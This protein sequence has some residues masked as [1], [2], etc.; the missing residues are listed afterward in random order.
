MILYIT[1]KPSQVNAL[2]DA[3]KKNNMFNNVEIVPLAGH[4]MSLYD[5]KDYDKKLDDYWA[6]LIIDK[7]VP[8]FPK[9]LKKKIKPKSS[10]IANNKKITTDYKKKFA[11][12]KAKI[13]QADKI[14]LAPD[15]D[16]EGATLV[17]EV[18]DECKA[19]SKVQGMIN[20]SKLDL[21]SLSQEV[22]ITT[23]IPY[24]NM[25]KAGDS[26]A[27][28]DQT[29]GINTSIIATIILGGGKTLQVGGV[30]LPTIRMVV[31]RDLAFE[32]HTEVPFWNI[33]AKAEYDKKVFDTEIYLKSMDKDGRFNNEEEAKNIKK[34]VENLL[35]GQILT[36]KELNKKTPPP[37]PYSLTDLQSEV[38]KRY[39][40][41]ADATLKIAQK[42]YADCKIQ[43]YP[44]TDSNYYSEGEYHSVVE[45]LDNLN[46]IS[47][48]KSLIEAIDNISKPLKR[49]IFDD[50]KID[51]HTALAPTMEANN[52]LYSKLSNIDK[53]VFN[54][55]AT[56]YIIQFLNDY[57][58]LD[59]SGTGTITDEIV[60]KFSENIPKKL[61]WKIAIDFTVNK[62]TIPTMQH[63][64]SISIHN[65][66]IS[67][68]KGT[69]KPKPRFT[70]ATLL[71]A[72]EK[73]HRFF[74][75]ENIKKEL[76]ENGIGTPATRAIILEQLKT[77]KPKDE[78]Y[79]KVD[80]KGTITSTSKARNLIKILPD[81][82]SSPILRAN[83]EAKLKEILH[84]NLSKEDYI[85]FVQ[86]T[87]K[88]INNTIF[89]LGTMPTKKVSNE[90]SPIDLICPLCNSEMV[91]SNIVYKCSKQKYSNG[92]VSGCK[93][94]LFKNSKP[95][96]RNLTIDDVKSLLD[97]KTLEG[98]SGNV[99]LN[100]DNKYFTTVEWNKNSSTT[101][102]PNN[103]T[104][105]KEFQES[106]K[107][108]TKNGKLVWK[109][110]RGKNLSESQC[111]RLLDG[112]KIKL[113]RKS[114]AGKTY[115]VFISLADDNGKMQVDFA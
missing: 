25:Y 72:M 73:V 22:K 113:K 68:T 81:K 90:V 1:E 34:E 6:N 20:M 26:R 41:S 29:F 109:N 100:L 65:D 69:T 82:I 88:E 101:S 37:K 87:V 9:E 3:L 99:I 54:L 108:F 74:D 13:L 95:L 51:A 12:I 49:K 103:K 114:Q 106:A 2:K 27:Y 115:E 50:S 104:N 21:S 102:T 24:M 45:I 46:T 97:G 84:G 10:F 4:I 38:N 44:R 47:N 66:S 105:S 62:R 18:I 80:K 107:T 60:F 32:K 89:E 58:Y 36:C 59:I 98:Q 55:V 56:R 53:K 40:L 78:P 31:E 57:E 86:T 83:M 76:G 63:N 111:E 92:K 17:L 8:F 93:F 79:F 52:S 48:F 85:L 15:P 7:R 33:K 14:I 77:S 42:L 71:K 35:R 30:K 70:E 67:I 61:G 23:K 110:F 91:D 43:S 64:D 11:D 75:D 5:F 94:S 112:K 19:L 96:G 39:K 16:N 28:F